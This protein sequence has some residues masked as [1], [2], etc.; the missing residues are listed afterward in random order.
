MG[1]VG[2][3]R[4]ERKKN[5]K[6]GPAKNDKKVR[7]RERIGRRKIEAEGGTAELTAR[8]RRKKWKRRGAMGKGARKKGR[9]RESKGRKRGNRNREGEKTNAIVRGECVYAPNVHPSSEVLGYLSRPK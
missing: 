3:G 1:R 4:R 8:E 5:R 2:R 6:E 9:A 7:R